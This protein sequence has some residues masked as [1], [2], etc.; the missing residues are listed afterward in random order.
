[1][2]LTA[3]QIAYYICVLNNTLLF[4]AENE[5]KEATEFNNEIRTETQRQ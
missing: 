2:N 4:V 5:R 3:I 1:M